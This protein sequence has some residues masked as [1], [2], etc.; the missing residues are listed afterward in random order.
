MV[1]GADWSVG[2]S[3]AALGES[4]QSKT[5]RSLD[6]AFGQVSLWQGSHSGVWALRVVPGA[7]TYE[8]NDGYSRL[9]KVAGR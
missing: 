5:R 1:S 3:K 2:V 4:V 7:T 9:D 6:L 8:T